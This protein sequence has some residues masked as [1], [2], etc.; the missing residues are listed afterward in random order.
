[1]YHDPGVPPLLD[2]IGQGELDSL[3][4]SSFSMV[5]IWGSHLD[6][7]D[8]IL[9]DISPSSIGNLESYPEN[10]LEFHS[11]YDYFNGGDAVLVLILILSQIKNMKNK[12]FLGEIIQEY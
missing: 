4:K 7:D 5:S 6:K 11:L 10:I 12:L 3:F 2:T 1:M 9:W 8:G